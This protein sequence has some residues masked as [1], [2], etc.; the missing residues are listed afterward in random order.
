MPLLGAGDTLRTCAKRLYK[1]TLLNGFI[2]AVE[3]IIGD[4][5]DDDDEEDR[6]E[7]FVDEFLVSRE[8]ACLKAGPLARKI[9]LISISELL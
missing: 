3:G 4:G 7:L 5:D 2:I 8:L 6:V 9:A 1:F